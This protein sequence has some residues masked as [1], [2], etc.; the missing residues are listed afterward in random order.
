MSDATSSPAAVIEAYAKGTANR[1]IA[2]L[3]TVFHP[4]AVMTGWL[5]PDFLH[6]GP[7]PFF[8]ALEANEVGPEYASE[9]TSLEVTDKIATASTTETHLLG[10]SFTNLFHLAQ[11]DDGSWRITSKLFRHH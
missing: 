8:A 1:D 10:M 6:G 7:E 11:L 5:G 2:L 3:K 9:T 4:N